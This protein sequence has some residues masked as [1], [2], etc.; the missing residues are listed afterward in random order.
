VRLLSSVLHEVRTEL[1]YIGLA[2]GTIGVFGDGKR[3][4][5]LEASSFRPGKLRRS[6][7]RLRIFDRLRPYTI[8]AWHLGP[9]SLH[10]KW[11]VLHL[12]TR[13]LRNLGCGTQL[14]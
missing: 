3:E 13:T 1:V 4:N 6:P 2:G 12:I 10:S 9:L 5:R 7:S 14:G 8:V 11:E